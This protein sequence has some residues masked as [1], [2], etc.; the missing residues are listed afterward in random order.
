MFDVAAR[1]DGVCEARTMLGGG[2][3]KSDTAAGAQGSA[4]TADKGTTRTGCDIRRRRLSLPLRAGILKSETV[5][6]INGSS[7]PPDAL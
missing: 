3:R 1:P 7:H 4:L 2:L 6:Q 5:A